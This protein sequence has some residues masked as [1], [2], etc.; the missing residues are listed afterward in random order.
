MIVYLDTSVVL[1]R[2]LGEPHPLKSWGVWHEAY[3]SDL[4]RL[5]SFRV[6][7]RIRLT[8]QVN[9]EEVA[10][11]IQT[12]QR[13]LGHISEIPVSDLILRRASQPFAVAVSTLDSLHLVSALLLQ[14]HLDQDVIFLTHDRK[15][16]MA[17]QTIGLTSQ[18]FVSNHK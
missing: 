1:R 10:Q 13:T 2:L 15:L 12:L 9:E 5:E 6:I 11:I 14:E 7:D 16:G 17:A 4:L 3:T 18:G 8:N